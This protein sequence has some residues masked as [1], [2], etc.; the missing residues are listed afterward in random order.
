[1]NIRE[2]ELLISIAEHPFSNQRE[3]AQRTGCSLG[4]INRLLRELTEKGYLDRDAKLTELASEALESARPQRA[5]ILAAGYGMRMVPI[6]TETPKGLLTVRGETLCE[7]LIRQLQEAGVREIHMV[8]GFMKEQY[9]FLMDRYGVDL[10]VN[11]DYAGGNNLLSIEKAARY[12][13]N[14]YVLPCDIWCAENPFRG[15]ELY[16]WYMVT[17]EKDRRSHFR[18]TRKMELAETARG[19]AGDRM[20][21]IA[22]L[23]G[24]V[25]GAVRERLQ[26]SAGQARYRGSTW[27]EAVLEQEAL[28]KGFAVRVMRDS[29][30]SEINTYE[31]LRELDSGSAQLRTDA[32][33]VI[34]GVLD[35]EPSEIH[36]IRVLKKGMTNRSFLFSCRDGRYIM[37]IPG[38]GTEQMINRRQEAEAYRLAA[39]EGFCEEVLYLNP[40]NGYKITRYEPDARV[41]DAAVESDLE[42]C[43]AVLRDLHGR[44]LHVGHTFD[45]FGQM[46]FYENLRGGAP[47]VYRDYAETKAH[48]R[49]L[50]P[51]IEAFAE[52]QVLTHIDAVPDN[53]L[54]VPDR[55]AFGDGRSK[56]LLIDWEYAGMQDPHTDLAMFCIYAMYDRTQVDRLIEIYFQGPPPEETRVKIYALIAACGLL[57]SNWCEYKRMLGVEFGAYSL[58]QYRY[59]KD[60]YRIVRASEAWRAFTESGK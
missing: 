33:R 23:T 19:E 44:R 24:D 11:R 10:I 40:D 36:D 39:Q 56:V 47:S 25:A 32:I 58:A 35:A 29:L 52:E 14:C 57:W 18:A 27:E 5:V 49:S 9:E 15:R 26:I 41:C 34:C 43:M 48:V 12:L 38:E 45:I 6:N 51:Y 22:Y 46:Q 4:I 30:F 16:P 60:Y 59:A 37:R 1:M 21:G 20:T 7:R 2:K 17:D 50:K 13:E 31:E 54:F 53:F 3:L 28:R 42:A 55:N 8:V